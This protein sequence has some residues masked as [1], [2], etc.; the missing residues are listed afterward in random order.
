MKGL[1][2]QD[3]RI[4]NYGFSSAAFS[5]DYLEAAEQV[6]DPH[7]ARR[8]IVLGITPHSLTPNALRDNGFREAKRELERETIVSRHSRALRSFFKPVHPRAMLGAILGR[9]EH[10]G[11]YQ[12]FRPDGWVSSTC[13]PE[14]PTAAIDAYERAFAGNRVS[15]DLVSN[16]LQAVARWRRSGIEVYGF[17]VP[18]SRGLLAV[19]RELSGFDEQ[20]FVRRFTRAGGAWIAVGQTSYHTY[21]GTH[22]HSNEAACLGDVPA[23][24]YENDAC[25]LSRDVASAILDRR[26]R[27]AQQHAMTR[28]H[29]RSRD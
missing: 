24:V 10:G 21:D 16:V 4:L 29:L 26:E 2:G 12:D 1:L 15:E 22:L 6:L 27:A 13:V 17:R 7:G 28:K 9:R 14:D 18:G 23:K 8:T 3:L 5:E 25:A 19:E 11:Y 20:D